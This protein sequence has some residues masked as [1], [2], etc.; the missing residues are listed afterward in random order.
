MKQKQPAIVFVFVLEI[1]HIGDCAKEGQHGL[2]LDLLFG[3]EVEVF[4]VPMLKIKC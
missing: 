4:G 3:K 1:D 2:K